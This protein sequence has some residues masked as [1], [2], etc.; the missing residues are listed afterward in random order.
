MPGVTELLAHPCM[1]VR[2]GSQSLLNQLH[3]LSSNH[4]LSSLVFSE[5]TEKIQGEGAALGLNLPPTLHMQPLS[6]QQLKKATLLP[7]AASCLET[8]SHLCPLTQLN[9]FRSLTS[10]LS[11][12]SFP[13]AHCF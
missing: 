12:K 7:K 5:K 2:P 4:H 8:R 11:M 6:F 10:S 1:P 9:P 3:A 13:L